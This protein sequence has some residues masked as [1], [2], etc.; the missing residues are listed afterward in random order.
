MAQIVRYTGAMKYLNALKVR[1]F[2]FALGLV[3]GALIVMAIRFATYHTE[4]THY[5][6]NFAVYINGQREQFKGLQYYQEV[7]A[8]AV[9]GAIQ[10]AQRAHMHDNLNSVLHVHDE[11]VTWQQFFTNLGW[12][13]GPDFI[14]TGDKVIHHEDETNKLHIVLNGQDLTGLTSIANQ[15][16]KDEDRLLISYGDIDSGA[17]QKEYKSVPTTAHHFDITPDPASCAGQMEHVTLSDRLHH[18]F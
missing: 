15:T 18:L 6:A 16:I 11:A 9:H 13:L 8:C 7:A 14:Q 2:L 17:I 10:P 5:H 3:L 1:W 4:T 12:T